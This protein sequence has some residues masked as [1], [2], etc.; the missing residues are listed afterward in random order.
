MQPS[1]L[2]L[3]VFFSQ[4]RAMARQYSHDQAK[5]YPPTVAS[6]LLSFLQ[7]T[8]DFHLLARA[9]ENPMDGICRH[10]TTGNVDEDSDEED[11]YPIISNLMRS[12]SMKLILSTIKFTYR[13]FSRI[14]E[15]LKE[16]IRLN[17][18]TGNGRRYRY[19]PRT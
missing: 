16:Q 9:A 1:Q 19:T 15:R 14:F 7:A 2:L 10:P 12:G 17:W 3:N 4:A 8:A 6:T 13:E 5:I 18:N 11:P